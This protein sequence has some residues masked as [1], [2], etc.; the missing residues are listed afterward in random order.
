MLDCKCLIKLTTVYLFVCFSVQVPKF[1]RQQRPTFNTGNLLD[2]GKWG[3]LLKYIGI[4][5]MG[6]K[7]VYTQ[8]I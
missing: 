1:Q 3:E 2:T 7:L 4:D 6:T 5:K 8:K